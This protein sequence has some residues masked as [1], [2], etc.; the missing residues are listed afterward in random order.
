[1]AFLFL[2]EKNIKLLSKQTNLI[3]SRAPKK[4]Q[5]SSMIS[6]SVP[7]IAPIFEIVDWYY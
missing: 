4:Y 5:I 1:M 7:P 2:I 3:S 6:V